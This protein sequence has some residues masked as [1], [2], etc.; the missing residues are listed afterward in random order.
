MN[1]LEATG[2]LILL[3]ALRCAV[4]AGLMLG[5][6]YLMNWWVDNAREQDEAR[7]KAQPKYCPS[8]V[9]Y[10]NR[11]WSVCMREQGALPVA[12][13]NCPI[14]KQAMGAA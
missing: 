14:Y 9:Q 4:P 11:C 3:F 7:K 1:E 12:C 8:Y 13:V 6:G 2:V 10:G 5:I